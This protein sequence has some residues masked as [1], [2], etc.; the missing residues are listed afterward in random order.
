MIHRYNVIPPKPSFGKNWQTDI[1][2][3]NGQG[4]SPESLLK[5][6]KL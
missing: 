4:Y 5:R 3:A 6:T 1:E 2:D